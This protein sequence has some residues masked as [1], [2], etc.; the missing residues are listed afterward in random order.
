MEQEYKDIH[1]A[2]WVIFL[3]LSVVM[4]FNLIAALIMG[5]IK[6][7]LDNWLNGIGVFLIPAIYI[8]TH[9]Y[10]VIGFRNAK[11]ILWK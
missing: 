6:F 2:L 4:N 7:I 10:L 11:E 1:A 9:F 8:F 3:V 5:D